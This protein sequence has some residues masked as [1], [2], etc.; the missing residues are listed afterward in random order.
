MFG[1]SSANTDEQQ[2]RTSAQGGNG[3]VRDTRAEHN[4]V[5]KTTPN[6]DAVRTLASG[7]PGYEGR[8]RGE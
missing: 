7:T 1:S 8:H 6:L 3:H 2:G 4:H 5:A